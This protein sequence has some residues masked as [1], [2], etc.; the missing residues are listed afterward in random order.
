MIALPDHKCIA[1]LNDIDR[2]LQ[3]QH[4]Q[5]KHLETL[6]GCLAHVATVIPFSNFFLTRLYRLKLRADC[7]RMTEVNQLTLRDL[8]FWKIILQQ[9]QQGITINIL[10]YHEPTHC[11]KAD[12][13]EIGLGGYSLAGCAWWW[14]IPTD[15]RN[16]ASINLLE[17]IV[18]LVGLWIDQLE[19]NLPPLS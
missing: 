13:C 5:S 19:Q 17:L 4:I 1:W 7:V 9:A 6:I 15:L 10:T 14:K 16:W 12:A 3:N 18:S 11:Y 2:V 8:L